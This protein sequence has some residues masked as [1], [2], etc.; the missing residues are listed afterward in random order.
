[1]NQVISAQVIPQYRHNRKD[2]DDSLITELSN[3]FQDRI[4]GSVKESQGMIR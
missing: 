4:K 2:R 3:V 1:M